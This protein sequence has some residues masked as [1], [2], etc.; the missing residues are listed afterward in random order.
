MAAMTTVLEE[1]SDKENSR[2]YILSTHAAGKP[3][4]V[5]QR[6]KVPSGNQVVM[7]DTVIVQLATEDANGV[8]MPQRVSFN[9]TV[10]RPIGHESAIMTSALATF[11]DIVAGDEFAD[12][13]N[14]QAYLS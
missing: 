3:A 5:I 12:V 4:R 13:V 1:F 14:K 8:V 9:I 6:R 7:E 11:R 2:V 10:A